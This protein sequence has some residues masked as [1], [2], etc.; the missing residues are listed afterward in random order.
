[1]RRDRKRR[2]RSRRASR[3]EYIDD[4]GTP[5]EGPGASFL[6]HALQTGQVFADVFGAGTKKLPYDGYKLIATGGRRGRERR[7][8]PRR[9]SGR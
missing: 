2:F 9:F 3:Q 1:M 4:D 7:F 5:R 6:S 8:R